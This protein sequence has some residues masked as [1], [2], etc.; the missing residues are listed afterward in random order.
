[1]KK[2]LII[3]AIAL[4]VIG[5]IFLYSARDLISYKYFSNKY[6]GEIEDLQNAYK[7]DPYGGTTPEE[8]LEL[9]VSA[10]KAGDA[11]SASNLFVP[12]KRKEMRGDIEVGLESGGVE[13]LLGILN[14][15]KIRIEMDEDKVRFEVFG[16]DEMIESS[17]DLV[18]NEYTGK[19]LIRDL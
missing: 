17:F 19:W 8:T 10:L 11:K 2:I 3:V 1:M 5:V 9:F 7:H 16:D 14:K 4:A 6:L 13:L 15:E 18:K 12:E